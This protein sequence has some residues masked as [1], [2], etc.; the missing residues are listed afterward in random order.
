[1]AEDSDIA[2]RLSRV[3]ER[4]RSG[5]AELR[6]LSDKTLSAVRAAVQRRWDQEQAAKGIG[7]AKGTEKLAHGTANRAAG[8]EKAKS[9]SRAQ[10]SKSNDHG[11]SY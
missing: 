3:G 7:V 6:P 9:R 8:K 1:M 2:K 10:D 4:F 5:S 11:H